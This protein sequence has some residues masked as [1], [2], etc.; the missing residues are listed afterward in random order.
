MAVQLAI[1]VSI[2]SGLVHATIVMHLSNSRPSYP[3]PGIDRGLDRGY[4]YGAPRSRDIRSSSVD[5]C[6]SKVNVLLSMH[7]QHVLFLC[8]L[9]CMLCT[10]WWCIT[11]NQKYVWE[12]D[13]GHT[14]SMQKHYDR[15]A[16]SSITPGIRTPKTLSGQQLEHINGLIPSY[17]YAW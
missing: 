11:E 9:D 5:M 2:D 12:Y 3:L 1:I 15:W 6:G 4:I 8:A 7:V 13:A 16:K 10:F 17:M 14:T